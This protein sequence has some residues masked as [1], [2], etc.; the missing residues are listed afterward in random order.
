[1]S[2]VLPPTH[3]TNVTTDSATN[4]PAMTVKTAI[5]AGTTPSDGIADIQAQLLLMAAQPFRRRLCDEQC[6][7]SPVRGPTGLWCG[8]AKQ[9]RRPM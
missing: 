2:P 7:G 8:V 1:M 4:D 5:T 6:Y 9:Q 3:R